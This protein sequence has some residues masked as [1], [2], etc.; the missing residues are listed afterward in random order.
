MADVA[1]MSDEIYDHM[2]MTVRHMSAAIVSVDT[3][4]AHS[5]QRRRDHA[6]TGGGSA[7]P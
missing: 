7:M 2:V 1:T 6:M 3:R 4:L 5:A